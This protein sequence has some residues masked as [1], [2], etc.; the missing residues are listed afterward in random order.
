MR[1]RNTTQM[2]LQAAIAISIAEWIG[3]YFHLYRGYWI[4]LTAMALIMQTWGES[5]KRSLERVSMTI[6]GGGFGTTLYFML[7]DSPTLVFCLLL[8]CVFFTVYLLQIYYLIAVFF[9]TC[10][11][12]FLFSLINEWTILILRDRILETGLGALIALSVGLF[13]HIFKTDKTYLFVDY[14]S[15]LKQCVKR[16]FEDDSPIFGHDL[17]KAYQ[18][19]RKQTVAIRYEFLF[20][21]LSSREFYSLLNQIAISTQHIIHLIEAYHWIFKHL[22]EKERH[23]LNEALHTTVHNIDGI[24]NHIQHQ[25][26]VVLLP[27]TRLTELMSQDIANDPERFVSLDNEA[28]GFFSLMYFFTR[29]NRSLHEIN[30]I[31]SRA[32]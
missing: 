31:L 2:A 8:F 22:N 12:V 20:H 9:L 11:V 25:K 19:L 21:R 16:L 23:S 30:H 5:V 28:L 32:L 24:I 17:A 6:L 10:F 3:W 1:L 26:E 27:V 4:T 15:Q 29:L 7:P 14:L 18:V 13:F